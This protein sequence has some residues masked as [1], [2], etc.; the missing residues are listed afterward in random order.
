MINFSETLN[1]AVEGHLKQI[2]A[3]SNDPLLYAPKAIKILIP[4]LEK[5]K[6]F[7][8]EHHGK[9][10]TEEIIFFRNIK[11]KLVAQLITYNEVY[12]IA[13][14]KPF[15]SKKTI[16]KYFKAELKKLETYA[17]DHSEFYKYYHSGNRYLDHK[18]FVRG[19][20]DLRLTLDSCYFQADQRFATSHDYKLARLLA[21]QEIKAFL[22]NEL[23]RL[24]N[25]NQY[26]PIQPNNKIKWT[27]S[28]VALIEL[29]YALH[30]EAAFNNGTTDLKETV[31]HF[32]TMFDIDLK[33][34]HRTFLEIRARK[35]ERT[36]FLTTLKDK[37]IHRMDNADEN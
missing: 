24:E 33:Q 9:S 6:A 5:L 32:E 10:K 14:N 7:F 22:E 15:A 37:L 36:K 25:T 35:S 4:A 23:N 20:H 29:I 34:F 13:T 16:R 28:K 19:Q 26:K 8:L 31:S 3:E 21:N 27:A 30:A 17:K 11:P 12:T 2:H 1:K 18:Y